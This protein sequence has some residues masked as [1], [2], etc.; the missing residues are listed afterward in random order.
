M[1]CRLAIAPTMKAAPFRAGGDCA[2]NNNANNNR[3]RKRVDD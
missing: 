3:P 1:S 2:D